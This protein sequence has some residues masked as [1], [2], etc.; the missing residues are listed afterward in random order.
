[1]K[2]KMI[3][4][5][6][7]KNLVDSEQMMGGLGAN[8]VEFVDSPDAARAI[9]VNT[10]GFIESAKEESIDTILE[11]VEMKQSGQCERVI[12]TGCLSQR[13]GDE[14]RKEIP[15]VDGIY[16]NRDLPAIVEQIT[17]ELRLRHELLGERQLLTPKHFAYL[18]ISEGCEHP[19]TFCAIPG[20]R[21]KFESR[22]IESLITESTRL[23]KAGVRELVL[24]AQD[25]TQYLSLIHI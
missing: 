6:C 10:C 8:G 18:K 24:I 25:S 22:P 12:V 15:E 21:G 9:I 14:L 2:V 3:T 19:C 17:R 20:I 1:M 5:G 7:P 11:A 4:L 16:G 13:Y 23:A